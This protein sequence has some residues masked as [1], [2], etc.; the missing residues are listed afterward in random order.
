MF[1]LL[2]LVF[3]NNMC[4]G[5]L[6]NVPVSTLSN[7]HSSLTV[8]KSSG[9]HS[10][11]PLYYTD[12]KDIHE[13]T[14]TNLESQQTEGHH[15]N[16]ETA[17]IS[18][19]LINSIWL[20]QVTL[21]MFATSIAVVAT[22]FGS[23][24]LDIS[25]LHWNGVTG[26][27][28]FYSLFD[29]QGDSYR[30]V[31]G[32]LATLPMVALG[33][34]VENSDN[35]DA[36][37]V[38]FSTT[39]MVISLFGRRKSQLEPT[40]SATSQVM[41]LSIAIALSTGISEELIFRGYI[42]TAIASISHSIPLSLIGQAVLFAG[43]HLSKNARPGENRLVG[44]IQLI[45]GLW[46][47]LVYLMTGG[48]LLPCIVSHFLYDCHIL[49]ETWMTINKQMDYTQVSSQKALDE[50]ESRNVKYLQEKAGALL[51]PD[52]IDFARR[53]FYAFDYDHAGGLTL[54]DTQR[55]MSYA[56]MNDKST[57][58]PK[59]V[60]DLFDQVQESK[61]TTT[62]SVKKGH[63]GRLNFSE[64]LQILLVLRSNS[65]KR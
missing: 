35:R 25:G 29:W 44:S 61:A 19:P 12:A 33:Y 41:L 65:S 16:H 62:T 36:S 26:T 6:N 10:T 52:T 55:A 45:N 13:I 4:L 32:F 39:N 21:L 64:F 43:G 23:H 28:T 34:L 47:G 8:T 2:A 48:D 3:D 49:C 15:Q 5:L 11:P 18:M 56:F 22:F 17:S 51:N 53:F 24:P 40:A 57:P 58:D 1:L 63:V 54:S 46:Y 30:Y 50:E 7:R 59:T 37:Q 42:P 27:E 14:T 9:L 20:N 38:N 31:E 60:E